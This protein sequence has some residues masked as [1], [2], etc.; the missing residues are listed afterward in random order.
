[1]GKKDMK[2]NKTTT[3]TTTTITTSCLWLTDLL[4]SLFRSSTCLFFPSLVLLDGTPFIR[5]LCGVRSVPCR[6]SSLSAP[7]LC[8]FDRI[9]VDRTTE[10]NTDHRPP[11]HRTSEKAGTRT[12][13][14]TAGRYLYLYLLL[15]T[16]PNTNI[17]SY[18]QFQN[19]FVPFSFF[20]ARVV[21][22]AVVLVLRVD[23]SVGLLSSLPDRGKQ[24]QWLGMKQ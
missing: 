2:T 24:E 16:V 12:N 7:T 17:Y 19:V 21:V 3:T 6:H 22:V 8:P 15:T 13:S 5:V 18:H 23:L 14:D 20:L 1:M 10:D 4:L 9:D 11:Y